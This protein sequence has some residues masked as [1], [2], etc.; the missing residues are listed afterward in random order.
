MFL[1]FNVAAIRTDFTLTLLTHQHILLFIV[2]IL[3]FSFTIILRTK[4]VFLIQLL[5][6]ITFYVVEQSP[7]NIF[8]ILSAVSQ[9]L[10]GMIVGYRL[11]KAINYNYTLILEKTHQIPR[12]HTKDGISGRRS[13][14]F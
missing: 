2:A 9:L 4:R 1:L 3:T 14:F 5:L 10:L 7:Q 11:L 12:N 6:F 13:S 8:Y